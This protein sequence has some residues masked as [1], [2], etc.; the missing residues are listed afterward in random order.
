MSVWPSGRTRPIVSGG[1]HVLATADD[2]HRHGHPGH[3]VEVHVVADRVEEGRDRESDEADLERLRET[4]E[5]AQSGHARYALLDLADGL[6]ALQQEEPEQH[7]PG[8]PELD[9][10]LE[11]H[12]VHRRPAAA[13]LLVE[14]ERVHA[15]AGAGD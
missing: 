5:L 10:V 9:R 13:A 11:A 14:S 4:E 6:D 2:P 12:I 3:I 15:D 8:E 1:L 7:E